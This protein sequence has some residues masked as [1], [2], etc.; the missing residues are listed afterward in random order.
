MI[1]TEKELGNFES[2]HNN[3]MK[4]ILDTPPTSSQEL[5]NLKTNIPTAT[6]MTNET[7]NIPDEIKP[8]GRYPKHHNKIRSMEHKITEKSSEVPNK[9][10]GDHEMSNEKYK[11]EGKAQNKRI[12]Q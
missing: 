6:H 11:T 5:I 8:K 1:P 12:F 3:I 9:R 7:N 4:R 2:T 10:G